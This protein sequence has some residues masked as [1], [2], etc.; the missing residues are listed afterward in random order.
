MAGMN[1]AEMR[2][3][4]PDPDRA[5]KRDGQPAGPLALELTW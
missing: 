4:S 2:P 1:R 5:G 3:R